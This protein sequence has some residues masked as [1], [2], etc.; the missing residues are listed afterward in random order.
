MIHERRRGD[1]TIST[2]AARLDLR[3]ILYTK[4]PPL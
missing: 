4:P 3:V 1:F 2:D